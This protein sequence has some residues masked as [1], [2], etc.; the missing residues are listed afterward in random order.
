MT[1]ATHR[2]RSLAAALRDVRTRAKV[3]V[4]EVARRLSVHH[5]TV[6]RWETGAVVP[7]AEDVAAYLAVI[8]VTGDERDRI[9]AL[10]R[11]SDES[12]WLI[13]GP[14][15]ISPQLASV[16]DYERTASAITVWA[17]LV[18]PGLLQTS[19]YAAA[20]ISRSSAS[21]SPG[22][23]EARVMVRNARRDA[24]TR[25]H[26]VQLHALVGLPALHGQIGGRAIMVSQLRHIADM[27]QR[28]NVTVQA[29]DLGGEWTPAHAGQFIL[30]EFEEDLS[31]VVYLEHHRSG[32]FLVDEQDVV[33]YK[34]A[35]ETIR[36]EAMSPSETTELIA[37]VIIP[38]METTT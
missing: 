14:P 33:D 13:S 7:S 18:I 25:L 9:L 37:S 8:S 28:D 19:D 6:S 36:R 24:L 1:R 29:Y 11:A 32:A 30:Y 35:A 31:P 10:A 22:E 23:V 27:A 20:I 4:R 21:I 3:S 26:P 12:D 17:P 15:G 2:A 5:T 38:S 34:A 16:M